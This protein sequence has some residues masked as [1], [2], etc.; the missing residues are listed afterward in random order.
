MKH[1][2]AVLLLAGVAACQRHETSNTEMPVPEPTGNL[3]DAER[4]PAPSAD[5]GSAALPAPELEGAATAAGHWRFQVSAKGDQAVLADAG[6]ASD[7]AMGV[8]ATTHRLVFPRP[9]PAAT[10]PTF[11]IFPPTGPA[12]FHTEPAPR[13]RDQPGYR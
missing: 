1:I 8:I 11:Q 12:P 9:A 4:V 2:V 5:I 6:E 7:F 13:G 3:Q 10:G